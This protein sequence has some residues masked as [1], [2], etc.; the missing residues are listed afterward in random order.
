MSTPPVSNEFLRKTRAIAKKCHAEVDMQDFNKAISALMSLLIAAKF[1]VKTME[2]SAKSD[3]EFDKVEKMFRIAESVSRKFV[4]EFT[5]TESPTTVPDG[6]HRDDAMDPGYGW[7]G[8][9]S[10]ETDEKFDDDLVKMLNER[11]VAGAKRL[12]AE[13]VGETRASA[14][15]L[16]GYLTV[17]WLF[18]TRTPQ[19]TNATLEHMAEKIAAESLLGARESLLEG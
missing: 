6:A 4:C 8:T 17:I 13:W 2:F 19:K 9:M 11:G 1:I 14:A 18:F 10:R 3:R 16:T 12:L 7:C 15:Y 5:R